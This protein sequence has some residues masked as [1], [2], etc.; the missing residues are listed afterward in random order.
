VESQKCLGA[1]P[2]ERTKTVTDTKKSGGMSKAKSVYQ[3][4]IG[5]SGEIQAKNKPA[6]TP[7]RSNAPSLNFGWETEVFMI[8]F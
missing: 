8:L 3:I 6:A 4:P 5:F 2:G 7:A 1:F